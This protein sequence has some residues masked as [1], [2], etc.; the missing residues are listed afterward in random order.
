MIYDNTD[1]VI[2]KLLNMIIYEYDNIKCK[3]CGIKY[4]DCDCFL[5][6]KNIKDNLIEYKYL[7]WSKNHQ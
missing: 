5:E 4:R 1:E 6:Y 3:T 7:C 2:K